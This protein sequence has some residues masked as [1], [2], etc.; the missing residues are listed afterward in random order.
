MGSVKVRRLSRRVSCAYGLALEGLPRGC[1][2]G[3]FRGVT[4]E[5]VL[6]ATV[7]LS[8]CDMDRHEGVSSSMGFSVRVLVVLVSRVRLSTFAQ[9]G[10]GTRFSSCQGPS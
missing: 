2:S 4:S 10:D 1:P 3:G 5:G 9:V 7:T 8:L 6:L